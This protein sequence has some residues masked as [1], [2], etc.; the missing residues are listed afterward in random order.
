MNH[1]GKELRTYADHG[2]RT[3]EDWLSRGRQVEQDSKPRSEV[4]S[5][6]ALIGVFSR[7]Q[8]Q[9]RAPAQPR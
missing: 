7:D 4:D 6:G 8:T 2:L 1:F 5:R 3:A 9:Q